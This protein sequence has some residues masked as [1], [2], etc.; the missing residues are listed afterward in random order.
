MVQKLESNSVSVP[1]EKG[2]L[3]VLLREEGDL[4]NVA[5]AGVREVRCMWLSP[6]PGFYNFPDFTYN[7]RWSQ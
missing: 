2:R 6:F 4:C 3:L 7:L 1:E 5:E